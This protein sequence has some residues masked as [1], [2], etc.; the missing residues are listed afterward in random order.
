MLIQLEIKNF[1]IIEHSII[2]FEKGFNVI[3]GETGAGKSIIMDALSSIVGER[4]SK[5]FVRRGEEKAELQAVFVRTETID[6][7]LKEK[8]I[9]IEMMSSL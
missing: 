2:N 8:N 9:H 3:T 6:N 7:R 4:T 5:G 1:A